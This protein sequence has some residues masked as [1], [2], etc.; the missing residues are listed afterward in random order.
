MK[1]MLVIVGLCA[2]FRSLAAVAPLPHAIYIGVVQVDHQS[3]GETAAVNIKVFSNDLQDALRNASS[4][5]RV[6]PVE[7]CCERNRDL[8]AAYFSD[9]FTCRINGRRLSLTLEECRS[10]NDV[11]WLTFRM[12]CPEDW[13]E[14]SFT[15]DFFMELFP[16]QSNVI[17]L[18]HGNE[19]RLFRATKGEE[20]GKVTL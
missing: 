2:V 15:A 13:K 4:R 12:S 10:E 20:T 6:G 11:H 8:I 3:L 5:Y 14:V 19:R 16:T 7:S 9:H 1:R 18:L 17:S